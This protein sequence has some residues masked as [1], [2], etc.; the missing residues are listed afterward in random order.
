SSEIAKA[1]IGE[2][3]WTG[4]SDIHAQDI[5]KIKRPFEEIWEEYGAAI[6]SDKTNPPRS[7]IANFLYEWQKDHCAVF[8]AKH[9]E[10][11]VCVEAVKQGFLPNN[12]TLTSSK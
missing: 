8:C 6:S 10:E 4:A 11:G 5:E 7:S 9:P 1:C 12:T 3:Q 2:K